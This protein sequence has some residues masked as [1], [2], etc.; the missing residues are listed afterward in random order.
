MTSPTVF[1]SIRT[2][3]RS[4]TDAVAAARN[5]N[6]PTPTVHRPLRSRRLTNSQTP[7]PTTTSAMTLPASMATRVARSRSHRRHSRAR[8]ARPPS[9]GKPGRRLNAA[10]S[11]LTTPRMRPSLVTNTHESGT[12]EAT[13]SSNPPMSADDAGPATATWNSSRGFSASCS[14]SDR[15]PKMKSRMRR[16]CSPLRRASSEW[17]S[18]WTSTLPMKTTPP[19]TAPARIDSGL[20]AG[21]A[22]RK[23]T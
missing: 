13:P 11:R 21:E 15:P 5:R 23:S 3:S 16:T 8:S 12:T 9:S 6:Q 18:S 17:D 7:A 20:E 1:P 19:T 10:S 22:L 2:R 14:I 4:R